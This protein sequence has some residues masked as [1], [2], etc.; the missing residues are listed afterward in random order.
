MAH[1]QWGADQ[2]PPTSENALCQNLQAQLVNIS[3]YELL[4]FYYHEMPEEICGLD[5]VEI[6]SKSLE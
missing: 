1:H 4:K 5:V 2:N 6:L 3:N